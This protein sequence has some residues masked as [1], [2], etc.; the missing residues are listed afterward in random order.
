[1]NDRDFSLPGRGPIAVRPIDPA[2]FIF[3]LGLWN[4][5]GD[6]KL[7]FTFFDATDLVIASVESA[8]GIGFF[9][10]V[11]DTGARR[12]V[13]DFVGGN[14]YVPT[15]DWQTAARPTFEPPDAA[16]PVPAAL[17]LALTAL[18]GLGLLRARRSRG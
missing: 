8:S 10:I 4:V 15:D 18:G 2:D 16:I 5:G 12:A 7:R 17:P 1:L 6:D 3:G 13:V 11:D 14:G 9:G